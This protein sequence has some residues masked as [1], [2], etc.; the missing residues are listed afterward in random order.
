MASRTKG[1]KGAKGHDHHNHQ[2]QSDVPEKME[3]PL[4][5]QELESLYAWVDSIPLSRPKRNIARDFSDGVQVAEIAHFF[6]PSYV[7]MHNYTPA[8]NTGGKLANWNVL[9]KKV[10]GKMNF[11]LA[12]DVINDLVCCKQGM[13]EK[14]LLMLQVK[15]KR[16]QYARQ[17]QSDK[18]EAD[19]HTSMSPG[20]KDGRTIKV[21]MDDT[22]GR[23][24][25]KQY[26]N[27]SGFTHQIEDYGHTITQHYLNNRGWSSGLQ[28]Q[29][30]KPK[31]TGPAVIPK[32]RPGPIVE[33]DSVPRYV[34]EEKEQEVLSRD[35]TIQMLQNKV[36]KLEQLLTLK[37]MRISELT[38]KQ[39]I[40][41][42]SSNGPSNYGKHRNYNNPHQYG[43]YR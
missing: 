6:F 8:N 24:K 20:R 3:Q 1:G 38:E 39:Y 2:A 33:S 43:G 23:L 34:V 19:Q 4:D 15:I 25:T 7:E 32:K 36:Q 41:S 16:A 26:S 11:E 5:E 12:D 31:K 17:H 28:D 10:F 35:E 9:N 37:D 30:P 29:K 42:T 22:K 21:G 40:N 27:F 13:I 18:P 14:V